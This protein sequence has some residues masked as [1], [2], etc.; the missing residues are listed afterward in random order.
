MFL[1]KSENSIVCQNNG[2]TLYNLH[3]IGEDIEKTDDAFL[4]V[5]II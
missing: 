2:F 3:T 4:S 5:Y 1:S